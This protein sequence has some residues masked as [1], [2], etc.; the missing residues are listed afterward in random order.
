[1]KTGKG[2]LTFWT[3]GAII[4][5]TAL[6]IVALMKYHFTALCLS[7]VLTAC[8]GG[9][10]TTPAPIIPPS[11][12]QYSISS[13][14]NAKKL[15]YY[16]TAWPD[17]LGFPATVQFKYKDGT[18]GLIVAGSVNNANINS[19]P[20]TLNLYKIVNGAWQ[21]QNLI[22]SGTV[23]NCINPRKTLATDLNKDGQVDFVILCHGV[24]VVPFPGERSR[25]L[26]SQSNGR[27]IL[28]Y[29]STD[30]GFWHGGSTIDLNGDGYPDLLATIGHD[31]QAFINNGSGRFTASAEYSF[32]TGNGTYSVELVDVNGDGKAD[33]LYGGHEWDGATTIILNPGNNKFAT[34][35]RITV[36]AVPGM[37]VVLDFVYTPANNSVYLLRTGGDATFTNFY[38]GVYV[39][40]YSLTTRI[41][42]II[43]NIPTYHEARTGAAPWSSW[44]PWIDEQDGYIVSDWGN[45]FKVKVE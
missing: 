28:D 44:L 22:D 21:Q 18:N 7:L 43:V 6:T 1:M 36:P 20:G 39:Q 23:D 16:A 13:Y 14:D 37:G 15:D 26:L 17:S 29:M 32:N 10:S 8:G 33:L 11:A 35:T 40:K 3:I 12:V 5:A 25:V 27:Y 31:I 2:P 42:S 34:G 41:S 19:L 38:Q 4:V 45:A 9:G 30:V 24:D